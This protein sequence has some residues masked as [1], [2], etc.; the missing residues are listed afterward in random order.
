MTIKERLG[1]PQI[2]FLIYILV[3]ALLIMIFRFIFPGS[4][5]PL[6]IYAR[7]WR[8]IQGVLEIFNFFPALVLS[9]L[10]IP[11]GIV[12]LEAGYQTFAEL[13]FK[14]LINSVILAI[15]GAVVYGLIF[16]LALPTVRNTE[17]D[18]LYKGELYQTARNGITERI[19]AGNWQEASQFLNICD[20]IWPDNP[21]KELAVLRDE[22]AINLSEGGYEVSDERNQARSLLAPDIRGSTYVAADVSALSGDRNPVD[23]TQAIT[24]SGEAFREE[25][26]FD[27]HWLA[28]LGTR[29]AADGSPQQA[30]ASRLASDAW[31]MISSQEPNQREE[32]VYSLY[33]LKLQGY[34]AMNSG[35]WVQAFYIFQ[36]LLSHTPDDPDAANFLAASERGV[37][38]IAFFVEEMDVFPG[39]I[40]TGSLFSLPNRYGRA[41]LRF[42]SIITS[43]DVAYGRDFELMTFDENSRPLTSVRSRYAKLLPVIINDKA[44]VFVLTHALNRYNKDDYSNSEWLLGSDTG[45]GIVLDISYED[46]LVLS[47]VRRGLANLQI[48]DLFTASRK[49]GSFGYITQIFDAEIIN[50][51]GSVLFF[52]PIAI[53]VIVLGWRYRVKDKPRYAFILMLPVLPVVFHGLVFLYRSA[54][55]IIGIWLVISFGFT[56][57]II[58]CIIAL[59]VTLFVSMIVLAA[60]H[61]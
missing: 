22:I 29:L 16:F 23:A 1:S 15:A 6:P 10:V 58:A 24:M 20:S 47:H 48:D 60:Q 5:S 19:S 12:S 39:E 46:L 7:S 18:M 53:F 40:L 41:A 50:R 51:L 43:A 49:L 44:Q 27:A 34:Q 21:D 33:Q 45:G 56:I 31:N 42:S 26:Y 57:S 14:R 52:L 55:N 9:A 38:E 4:A 25:R 30:N 32:L 54:V 17:D 36:E 61:W 35:E 13:F 28:V 59:T 8:L 11:F 2:I 37:M 3:S